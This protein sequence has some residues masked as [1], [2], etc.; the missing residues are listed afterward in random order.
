MSQPRI[1]SGRQATLT[2][3]ASLP[4]TLIFG[5]LAIT[6]RLDWPV[7]IGSAAI[8][9]LM[10]GW[11]VRR[12]LVDVYRILKFSETLARDGEDDLPARDMS[13]LFPEFAEAVTL[14]Q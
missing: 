8:S 6:S 9:V 3:L 13:G 10:L 5:A 14:L 7:A 4:P 2:T 12:G 11:M 1:P